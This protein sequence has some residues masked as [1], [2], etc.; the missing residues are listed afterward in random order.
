MFECIHYIKMYCRVNFFGISFSVEV[1]LYF[2]MVCH[3]YQLDGQE[4]SDSMKKCEV[5]HKVS[6]VL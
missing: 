1:V 6:N 3:V 5:R 2:H 4:H